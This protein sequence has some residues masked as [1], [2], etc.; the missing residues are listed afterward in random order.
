LQSPLPSRSSPDK[1]VISELQTKIDE[2]QKGKQDLQEKNEALQKSIASTS[3]P[4]TSSGGKTPHVLEPEPVCFNSMSRDQLRSLCKAKGLALKGTKEKLIDR[5]QSFSEEVGKTKKQTKVGKK[6]K[7]EKVVEETKHFARARQFEKTVTQFR[8]DA[9]KLS[10]AVASLEQQTKLRE[11]Q[12]TKKK[13]R[14][15]DDDDSADS[16]ADESALLQYMKED[17]END[18]NE[19][20]KDRRE[21]LTQQAQEEQKDKRRYEHEQNTQENLVKMGTQIAAVLQGGKLNESVKY[22]AGSG[23]PD[24][25][26]FKTSSSLEEWSSNVVY[27]FMQ[28]HGLT[29][30]A[31]DLLGLNVDG[32]DVLAHFDTTS[33]LFNVDTFIE[34]VCFITKDD[35]VK[36]KIER[37]FTHACKKFK[38]AE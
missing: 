18:R 8:T 25:A 3:D 36:R 24:A 30:V 13:T 32:L 35:R 1:S 21:R 16:D 9:S 10:K 33:Q 38:A 11:S 22:V 29:A 15:A 5:L 4:V 12:E 23:V 7:G 6:K 19:R 28:S 27:S 34:D 37:H 2:L 14:D 31:T 17:R 20:D 26:D